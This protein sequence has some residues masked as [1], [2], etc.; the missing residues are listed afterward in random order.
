MI[1]IN[2]LRTAST[3]AVEQGWN[4]FPLKHGSTIDRHSP[5]PLYQVAGQAFVGVPA[6]A[7]AAW[8]CSKVEQLQSI[9]I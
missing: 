6:P 4:G 3:Q 9:R 2:R 5:R 8:L 1:E 7:E